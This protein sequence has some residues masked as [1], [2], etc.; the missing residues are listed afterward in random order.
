MTQRQ[1][2]HSVEEKIV[3]N[4]TCICID[5]S[6]PLICDKDAIAEEWESMGLPTYHAGQV[7]MHIE[8]LQPYT[9]KS[10]HGELYI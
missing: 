10:N 1:A 7:A 5:H 4:Y 3:Q 8:N 2:H 6:T 9:H